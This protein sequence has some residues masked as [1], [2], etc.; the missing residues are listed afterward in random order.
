MLLGQAESGKSTLQKQFQLYYASQSLD[1]ERPAWRPVVYFNIVKAIRMILEELEY[2]LAQPQPV[3][4]PHTSSSRSHHGHASPSASG[5]GAN[6]H[7]APWGWS[8]DLSQ[9]RTKLLPLIA[10][11]DAIASDLSGGV[12][13]AGGKAGVYV[14]AGW[15]ALV[16]PT[17]NRA[18]PGS[19]PRS[20]G[21]GP[22]VNDLVARMLTANREEV[23][24]LWNHPV[25]RSLL[26]LR[27]LRLEE[28][29]SL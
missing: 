29:A 10:V 4:A 5:S 13:F 9:L 16:T 20:A 6:G 23:Y 14:R 1:R 12:T 28:S 18:W 7:N 27:K 17:M 26:K 15:Q 11:E 22:A 19:A 24:Q 2:E 25:V 3:P 21:N 8:E